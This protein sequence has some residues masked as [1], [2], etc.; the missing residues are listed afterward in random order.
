[1]KQ[2][3]IKVVSDPEF[4]LNKLNI[5]FSIQFDTLHNFT[6]TKQKTG[7]Y[8]LFDDTLDVVWYIG[9]SLSSK[10]GGIHAR[11][12]KHIDRA[13]GT[14]N[15]IHHKPMA[16]WV[17]F[18]D[19]IKTHN[20][21]F[22]NNGE[23]ASVIINQMPN[24]YIVD[25]AEIQLIRGSISYSFCNSECYHYSRFD[26]LSPGQGRPAKNVILRPQFKPIGY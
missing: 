10:S 21:P 17:N 19:W 14:Y 9:K 25:D 15:Q 16:N 18:E 8:I 7:L 24:K 5:P 13:L 11:I 23:V 2:Q 12:K 20:Y 1:M 22:M 4:I 26:N 6:T 3:I